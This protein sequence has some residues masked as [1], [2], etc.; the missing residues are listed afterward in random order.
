MVRRSLHDGTAWR[1]GIDNARLQGHVAG[2]GTKRRER[3][4]TP[5]VAASAKHM[6]DD[7]GRGVPEVPDGGGAPVEQAQARWRG[8][9][10]AA[11]HAAGDQCRGACAGGYIQGRGH[12][13][14]GT[15]QVSERGGE[16][17]QAR[18]NRRDGI[19]MQVPGAGAAG[20]KVGPRWVC[21]EKDSAALGE[22]GGWLCRSGRW[23]AAG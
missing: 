11:E 18:R 9:D 6:A 4:P 13:V 23:G 7:P 10:D 21:R 16:V 1:D 3:Q 17:E 2:G 5:L 14:V 19:A 12:M 15:V 22:L 20:W 8:G